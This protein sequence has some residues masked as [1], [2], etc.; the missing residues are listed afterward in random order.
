MQEINEEIREF[1][2]AITFSQR[3]KIGF[4]K[5]AVFELGLKGNS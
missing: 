3:I 4:L 1:K 2:A 5:E